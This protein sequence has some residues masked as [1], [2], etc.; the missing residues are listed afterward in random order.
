[1]T[2]TR[3]KAALVAL[4]RTGKRRPSAY[5]ELVEEAGSAIDALEADEGLLA[6]Q[7]ID[8]AA[9][10][11]SAWEGEGMRVVT[12]LDPGY[13][14]NL[15]AVH[16]R[17]P[18]VFVAG[19]LMPEDARSV[20]VVGARKASKTGIVRARQIAEQLVATGYTVVSGL[21]V[22]ID[23][24]AHTGA[25]ERG[26]RTVAVIGTGLSHCYPPQ[27]AVLQRHIASECAVVSQFWPDTPPNRRTFPMRNAV[28]S[29]MSLATVIVEA[30]PTSGARLQARLALSHGRSVLLL[31]SLVRQQRWAREMAARPGTHVVDSPAS[32]TAVV[33][34]LTSS[35]MLVA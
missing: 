33:E 2:D 30:S 19:G 6:G 12:V 24:A 32:L 10:R 13:P 15:R 35:G 18:L 3:E 17:P 22:G 16:D 21:A 7:M 26:G 8:E 20:A 4:L 11:I 27:N 34:R 5:A 23:T 1:V 25:L 28:M 14:E 31:D 9:A 29:G